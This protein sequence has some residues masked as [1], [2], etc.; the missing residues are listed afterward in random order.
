MQGCQQLLLAVLLLLL[1]LLLLVVTLVAEGC[2]IQSDLNHKIHGIHIGSQLHHALA[3]WG[4]STAGVQGSLQQ[5]MAHLCTQHVALRH[6][7]LHQCPFFGMFG[8]QEGEAVHH[9][10]QS[11]TNAG[12]RKASVFHYGPAYTCIQTTI[13]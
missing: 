4:V 13:V 7:K 10:A 6:P 11:L 2:R 5:N 8:I 1:L 12:V 3:C 9:S